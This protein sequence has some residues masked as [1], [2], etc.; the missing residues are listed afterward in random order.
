[1]RRRDPN[2]LDMFKDFEPPEVAPSYPREVLAA[3]TQKTLV[4]KTLSCALERDPRSRKD[5]VERLSELLGETVSESQLDS[6]SSPAKETNNIPA[7]KLVALVSALHAERTANA[8]EFLNSLLKDSGL[9]V[10]EGRYQ[11][12]ID[13]ELA[14]ETAARLLA[15]AEIDD[16]KWKA[17]Q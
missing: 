15:K 14:K 6:W 13:R 3:A 2:T 8:V 9:I 5:I 7:Y 11:S 10:C 12:L 16:A 1:M 17:Q 4:A